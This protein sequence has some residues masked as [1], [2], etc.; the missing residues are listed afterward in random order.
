MCVEYA[1]CVVENGR[2][3]ILIKINVCLIPFRLFS[4]DVSNFLSKL[5]IHI[6]IKLNMERCAV[7]RVVVAEMM[8]G[9]TMASTYHAIECK[10]RSINFRKD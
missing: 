1:L 7:A 8:N 3:I 9:R 6:L 10:I 4:V 5:N 2:T